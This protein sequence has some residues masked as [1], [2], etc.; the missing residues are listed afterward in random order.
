MSLVCVCIQ[1]NRHN[2][3][4][5]WN[6]WRKKEERSTLVRYIY[7]YADIN[8]LK[9]NATTLSI[10]WQPIGFMGA[11]TM[12]IK[13]M[14]FSTK[15]PGTRIKIMHT[16]NNVWGGDRFWFSKQIPCL[17]RIITFFFPFL[18]Y[19]SFAFAFFIINNSRKCN[20]ARFFVSNLNLWLGMS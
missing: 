9:S 8:M 20:D 11:I 2:G 5:K 19:F 18:F 7:P 16:D 14:I 4:E 15:Y 17:V 12:M 13:L 1:V 10:Q 3:Q 6:K